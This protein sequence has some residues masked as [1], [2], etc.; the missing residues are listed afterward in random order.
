MP[1]RSFRG[2]ATNPATGE[3]LDLVGKL[4]PTAGRKHRKAQRRH[5]VFL[6]TDHPR[7]HQLNL[8]GQQWR[9]FWATVG[10]MHKDS[11]S[12]ARISTG[13]IAK[14]AEMSSSQ[15]STVLSS[16]VARRIIDRTGPGVWAVNPWLVYAGS[17]EDW[18][19]ATDAHPEPEW[20]RP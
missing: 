18:E 3:V 20:N 14:I 5:T 6:L 2:E 19:A 13:E 11:G 1:A 17:A 16:L 15:A 7:M 10:V 12:I 4:D 9:V 8:T